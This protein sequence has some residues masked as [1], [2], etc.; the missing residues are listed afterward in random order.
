MLRASP[1]R[2]ATA[3][4]AAVGLAAAGAFL[5]GLT[6]PLDEAL[7]DRLAPRLAV[8][9]DVPDVVIVGI[10]EPTFAEYG[11]PWPWPR[12]RHAALIESLRAAGAAAI[13][14]DV[15]FAEPGDP[16]A[17]AAL[18]AAL[19]PDVVLAT[20][21]VRQDTPQGQIAMTVGP[22]PAL[23]ANAPRT[24][25]IAVPLDA[26]GAVRRL[27]EAANGLAAVLAGALPA[28]AGARI[29]FGGAP[30]P[31]VSFY[32]A[33]EAATM[34]PAGTFAGRI[35]LVG[36][37]LR[38][39]P[40]TASDRFRTPE[41]ALGRGM[42]PGVELHARILQTL[43]SQ[44]WIRPLPAT[45]VAA[46]ALAMAALSAWL[47]RGRRPAVAAAA[48]LGL[49]ALPYAC[50]ATGL[51]AG[52]WLPPVAPALAALGAGLVQSA[53]DYAREW[54]ARREI[55]ALFGRYMAPA[56]VARLAADPAAVRLGGERREI[57]VMFCDLRG[58]TTLSEKL[59]DQPERLTATINAALSVIADAVIANN[60]LVD[61]F[62]GDCV[63][64]LWNAPADDPDHAAHAVAAGLQAI[65]GIE[66][67][68]A[69]LGAEGLKDGLACGVGINSGLCTVGN[70][71]SSQRFDYTAL[72]D[73]VNV[74]ARIE[75][76]T[77]FY[78][79]SM[80]IGEASAARLPK[81]ILF[82]VDLTA[83]RGRAEPLRLYTLRSLWPHHPAA[84]PLQARALEAAADGD[85]EGAGI[86]WRQM[87][88][89]A[90]E[91][92]GFVHSLAAARGAI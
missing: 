8:P 84:L 22:F 12:Q 64:G 89:I 67:L 4:A 44:S 46:L 71:G 68:S 25:L 59:S 92:E 40:D 7:Y 74:A 70:M 20:D 85:R 23:M 82:G 87:V 15:V 51:L 45:T 32:Q 6:A 69:R 66:S 50:S 43:A 28:P 81:D 26:D 33:A 76:M 83:V 24:G 30:I 10:D 11:S 47:T 53:N 91:T 90:P 37:V 62:I 3:L 21:L 2:W 39:S 16:A 60:G 35:V 54:R 36:L 73:A 63:M 17:D 19:G 55:V 86:I 75:A 80:L 48:T 58:F 65:R 31:Q 13:G 56:L 42:M 88:Q 78:G 14:Y 41:T 61:K 77:K 27:P 49:T 1:V 5:L 38:S 34:L 29:R 52:L 18:A 72:G 79:L 9:G 57:T